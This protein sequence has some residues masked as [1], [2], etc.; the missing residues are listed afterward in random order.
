M[1]V[2]SS[3]KKMRNL[4]LVQSTVSPQ[5]ELAALRDYLD[6][7]LAKNFIQH[8]K[9]PTGAPILFVKKK[10]DSLRMCVDY[11]GLNKV[12]ITGIHC[13]L[14]QDFLTN[15]VKQRST[16]SLIFVEHTT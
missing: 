6:E 3:S 5:N 14:F 4:L 2:A 16:P 12:T 9:S 15:S 8:S 10:D 13:R 1:I 11:R 7:N